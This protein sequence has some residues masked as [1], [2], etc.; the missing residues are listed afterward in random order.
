MTI[1]ALL[2]LLLYYF[3]IYFFAVF[4]FEVCVANRY[5]L[6]KGFRKLQTKIEDDPHNYT[7]RSQVH[8]KQVGLL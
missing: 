5:K 4:S 8:Q 2:C 3:F 6:N 7:L 1:T